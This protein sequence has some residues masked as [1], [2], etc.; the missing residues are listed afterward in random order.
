V[1]VALL[2]AGREAGHVDGRLDLGIGE[3]VLV[4]GDLAGDITEGAAHRG[5]H[6][7]LGREGNLG[8]RGV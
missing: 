8:V 5:D 2:V 6:H 4:E 3:V 1:A 7:M